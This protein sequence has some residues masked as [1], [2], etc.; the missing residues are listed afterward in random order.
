MKP[1]TDIIFKTVTVNGH[2]W[3]GAWSYMLP[4]DIAWIGLPE[5]RF[6]TCDTCP[7]VVTGKYKEDCKC[8]THYPEV[9]NF[10]LGLALKDP[11]S[12]PIVE[13]L[14]KAG[15]GLPESL[16][17]PPR[18]LFKVVEEY[19]KGG[20]GNSKD[21]LCPFMDPAKNECSIYPYRNS[22]CAT[23]FCAND[24]GDLGDGFWEKLQSLLGQVEIS[25]S[26]WAMGKVGLDPGEYIERLNSL[27]G[28]IDAV[29][30]PV[31]GGWSESARQHLFGKWFGRECEFYER[32]ADFVMENREDLY[33]IARRQGSHMAFEFESAVQACVPEDRRS[34]LDVLPESPGEAV[35]IE[36]LWYKVQ[37]HARRLW[38]LP[39]NEGTVIFNKKMRVIENPLNNP[40][41]LLHKDKPYVVMRPSK[42]EGEDVAELFMTFDEG[43][44]LRLFECAQI[45]GEELLETAQMK[46]LPNP[47]GFIAECMRCDILLESDLA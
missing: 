13:K 15:H 39:Y 17:V 43:S 42:T 30:D 32:C 31:T 47:K 12:R 6:A 41:A 18:R 21:I 27:A 35:P 16:Q 14:V 8:C 5:E 46:A 44:A 7:K 24:H 11:L 3:P 9:S 28:D 29:S 23:F 34:E 38:A 40:F 2:E 10:M 20:F 45:I 22:I 36:D 25:L 33:D 4:A 1:P 37:L 19:V 26:Q